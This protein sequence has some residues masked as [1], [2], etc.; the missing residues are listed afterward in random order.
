MIRR[1]K[2]DVLKDLPAK[3]RVKIILEPVVRKSDESIIAECSKALHRTKGDL[4]AAKALLRKE[5]IKLS[6]IL[7]KEYALLGEHKA[8]AIAEWAVENSTPERPLVVFAHHRKVLDTV[9]AL[10]RKENVSFVR[11]DGETPGEVRQ[12][13]VDRFQAGEAQI[14]L[15]SITAASMG[16]TLTRSSD[17]L[18]AELPFGPGLRRKRRIGSIVCRRRIRR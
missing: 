18:I 10:L 7:F 11:I 15:L 1:L 6:A 17:M 2:A 12:Q 16:L 4:A 9:E 14:A 13:N 3:S 8:A 5:R